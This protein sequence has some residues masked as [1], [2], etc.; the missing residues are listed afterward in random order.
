MVVDYF[1]PTAE[2]VY[3]DAAASHNNRN[4]AT[5][6]RW[7]MREHP[8]EVHVRHLQQQVRLPGLRS[9]DDIHDAAVVLVEAD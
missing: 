3:G 2:R 8:T 4:A 1:A 5:L 6:A 7:I 9:A